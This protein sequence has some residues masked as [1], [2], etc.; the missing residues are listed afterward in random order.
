MG[1]HSNGAWRNRIV[2]YGTKAADQFEAHPRNWRTHPQPQR[3]ALAASLNGVGWVGAV[4][5]NVRT[6]HVLDGH[7]R[8]W[9][10]LEHN[11]EVPYLQVDVSEDEELL[12]LATFDPITQMALTDADMLAGILADLG[13]SELVQ[14]DEGLEDL[15][16]SIGAEAGVMPPDFAPV[17]ADE[18]PRLDQKKPIVCPHCGMEF[19]PGD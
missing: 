10:A 12:V 15:L 4:I 14:D 6:G 7:E 8:I 16:R 9:Q 5:E 11:A 19:V 2:G 18:Q 17:G 3:E 13:T 1:K